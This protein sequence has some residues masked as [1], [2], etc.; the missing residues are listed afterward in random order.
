M[1]PEDRIDQLLRIYENGGIEAV[2]EFSNTNPAEFF[3]A[4]VAI[5]DDESF[6]ELRDSM[7]PMFRSAMIELLTQYG[8][9]KSDEWIRIARE[10]VDDESA[11]RLEDFLR[12]LRN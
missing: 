5:S 8:F 2:S 11:D 10:Q 4:M 3:E 12:R 7:W 9:A 1:T 6:A